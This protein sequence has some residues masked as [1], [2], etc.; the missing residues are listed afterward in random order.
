MR[1]WLMRFVMIFLAMSLLGCIPLRPVTSGYA[2][3]EEAVRSGV[4]GSE[5]EPYLFHTITLAPDK[6]FVGY[7]SSK[8]TADV[9][10][11]GYTF[12]EREQGGWNA[13]MMAGMGFSGSTHAAL[14]NLVAEDDEPEQAVLFLA[15]IDREIE[16]AEALLPDGRSIALFPHNQ[17]ILAAFDLDFPF[18]DIELLNG[19]GE[20][21]AVIEFVT[22][23]DPN[24]GEMQKDVMEA[25]VAACGR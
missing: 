15:L 19:E 5:G 4:R 17:M 1:T 21:V 22:G 2:S 23:S 9:V 20:E 8:N 18:C 12:V 6:A 16:S 24:L 7:S 13:F 11:L 3:P 14:A 25:I 10:E